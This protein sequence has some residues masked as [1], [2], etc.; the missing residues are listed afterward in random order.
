M[1]IVTRRSQAES[2]SLSNP[3]PSGPNTKATL[4]WTSD[5]L[6]GNSSGSRKCLIAVLSPSSLLPEV[7]T[8]IEQSATAFCSVS[9]NWA[10]SR[11]DC[12]FFALLRAS[13]DQS[14][15][16]PTIRRLLKPKLSIER[17]TAPMLPS[18]CGFTRTM[19]ISSLNPGRGSGLWSPM[20]DARGHPSRACSI[21]PT[22][23]VASDVTGN[24]VPHPLIVS[25]GVFTN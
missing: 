14:P 18:F 19:Q 11:T 5:N 13:S 17:A 4:P 24:P 9:W 20:S 3:L 2:S 15:E 7:P 23:L 1:G 6:D 16:R 22:L 21:C 25:I 8:T 10:L 12:A